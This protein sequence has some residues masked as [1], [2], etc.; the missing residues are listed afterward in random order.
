MKE[1]YQGIT[2]LK[3]IS[4]MMI[5]LMHVACNGEY[6]I[7]GLVFNSIIKN[8]S[9]L[10]E[11]FFMLSAFGMC[12]GYYQKVKNNEISLKD[13]YLR[14]YMKILPFFAA[15]VI[16]D[17]LYS[18]LSGENIFEAFLNLTLTFGLFPDATLGIV[19]VGWTLGVIFAFYILF[20][21]FVFLLW[22]KKS[23]WISL[24]GFYLISI[25]GDRYLDLGKEMYYANI[26]RW[27]YI[28][29]IGGLIFL[30]KDCLIKVFKKRS[31]LLLILLV[32]T[33]ASEIF[34]HQQAGNKIILLMFIILLIY[35][36]AGNDKVFGNRPLVFLGNYC[37]EIYLSHMIIFRVFEKTGWIHPVKN[38]IVSFVLT[39]VLVLS[40]TIVFVIVAKWGIQWGLS[41]MQKWMKKTKI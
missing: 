7:N 3:A 4:I 19:S 30:Y 22:N 33:V 16:F 14:R 39:Y 21:F 23:A 41:L 11:L 2:G 15:I 12:C 9:V 27:L 34:W 37:L 38:E 13:F 5:V 20:P 36:F 40:A 31:Y 32:G 17:L 1:R 24:A 35:S 25:F 18:G 8:L 10:I 29:I 26:M 6:Q 28:F